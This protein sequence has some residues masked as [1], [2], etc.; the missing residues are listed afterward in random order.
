VKAARGVKAQIDD[1]QGRY[2]ALRAALAGAL[3]ERGL[4]RCVS[5][6]GEVY[7]SPETVTVSY[8]A[9]KLDGEMAKDPELAARLAPF[10]RESVRRGALV[11][12]APRGEGGA[13]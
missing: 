9:R 10:R 6:A 8:D 12:R 4:T 13:P 5:P 3:E 2:D 1:L 11:I 7:F